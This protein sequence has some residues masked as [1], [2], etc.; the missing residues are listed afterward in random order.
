MSQPLLNSAILGTE[1]VL[2]LKVVGRPGTGHR[3]KL[4]RAGK[5]IQSG[6]IGPGGEADGLMVDFSGA[7]RLVVLQPARLGRALAAV[8][9][10]GQSIG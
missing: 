1:T 10:A 5:L 4:Y 2:D 3:W 9:A 6:V 7:Y 8:N